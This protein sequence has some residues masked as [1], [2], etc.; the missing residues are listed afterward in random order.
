M[1]GKAR[2]PQIADKEPVAP[3]SRIGQLAIQRQIG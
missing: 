3:S 2:G 1:T